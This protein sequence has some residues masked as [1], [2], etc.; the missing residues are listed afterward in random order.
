MAFIKDEEEDTPQSGNSTILAGNSGASSPPQTTGSGWTNLQTYLD[1]NNGKGEGVANNI[2]SKIQGRVD[3][4]NSAADQ[5]GADASKRVAS[6]AR[7]DLWSDKIKNNPTGIDQR[8]YGEWKA[9]ANYNGP[10]S[11]ANDR[12]YASA[13]GGIQKAQ[14]DVELAGDLYGQQA[15]ARQAFDTNGSYTT[16]QS[17]LDTFIARGDASG[18]KAFQDFQNKNQDIGSRW[19]AKVG[20][21]N[22][23]I[24]G[25]K[26]A[27]QSAYDNVMSAIAQKYKSIQDAANPR[28]QKAI[29]QNRAKA[30]LEVENLFNKASPGM[31][32]GDATKYYSAN[33]NFGLQNVLNQSEIEALNSLAGMDDS[34]D[35]TVGWEHN[36]GQAFNVDGQG[37]LDEVNRRK[38]AFAK[39]VA[40][41][42]AKTLE[43]A[44]S[45]AP[46]PNLP[47]STPVTTAKTVKGRKTR[48]QPQQ[49]K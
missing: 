30:G 16:G 48:S 28:V 24:E 23:D 10:Q 46:A 34:E 1:A 38:A 6:S 45:P 42:Q 29:D 41:A 20:G 33:N 7:Q 44:P 40:A 12:G 31:L 36:A 17:L 14:N 15:L 8:A 13:Y 3:T 49:A 35:T 32:P 37:V 21:L 11:A 47:P 25:A 39:E 27:G 26:A 22:K 5:W 2:T 19:D 9:S 18:K 43:A 4:A